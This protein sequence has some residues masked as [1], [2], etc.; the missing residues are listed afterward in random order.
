MDPVKAN[1]IVLRPGRSTAAAFQTICHS[2]L[3]HLMRNEPLFRQTGHPEALHQMR[4]ALR[5]LRAALSLFKKVVID[6]RR[7]QID[8]A[9]RTLVH[10]LNAARDTDQF[11]AKVAHPVSAEHQGEPGLRKLVGHFEKRRDQAFAEARQA[12]DSDEFRDLIGEIREWVRGGQ[13]LASR[14]GGQ[15][16]ERFARK[17]LKAR[18]RK[19]AKHARHLERLSSLQQH[20]VRIE[21]KKLRY[22]VQFFS[23]LW[24]GGKRA[25]RRDKLLEALQRMQD[26]LG[27]SH[28]I[29]VAH[30]TLA[31]LATNPPKGE[32]PSRKL[33]FAAGLIVGLQTPRQDPLIAAACDDYRK[34]AGAKPFWR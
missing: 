18:R 25:A 22:G 15:P 14:E 29:T 16:V 9:L 4:V 21:A 24:T 23:C 17:I 7:D 26:D 28:D 2:C 34:F 19:L 27:G 32:P 8:G 5:R 33:T 20:K 3:D 11:L 10:Q 1:S 12:I 6:D 13:W 31:E 30:Q